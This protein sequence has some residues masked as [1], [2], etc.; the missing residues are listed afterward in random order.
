MKKV[1]V[2]FV[3]GLFAVLSVFFA[4]SAATGVENGGYANG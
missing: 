3:S 2:F 4:V 1:Q